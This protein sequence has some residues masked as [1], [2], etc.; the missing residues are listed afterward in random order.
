ML[1]P[2]ERDQAAILSLYADVV[3]GPIEDTL[4]L[5]SKLL[6]RPILLHELGSDPGLADELRQI[7]RPLVEA[8]GASPTMP[9]PEWP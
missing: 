4:A 6:D 1:K 8:I 2:L 7:V 9:A 3:L 5:A